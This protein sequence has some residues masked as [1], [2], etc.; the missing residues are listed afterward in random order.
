MEVWM[1]IAAAAAGYIGSI[2]SWPWIR[3]AF[4]GAEAEAAKLR[5]R[6]SAVLNAA[7]GR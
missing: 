5:D 2:Y 6:A 3:A 7:R 4:I 1:L